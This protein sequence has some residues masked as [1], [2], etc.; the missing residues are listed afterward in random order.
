LA[1]FF[2]FAE[3]SGLNVSSEFNVDNLTAFKGIDENSL[4]VPS[5][6]ENQEKMEV[7]DRYVLQKIV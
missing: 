7:D 6:D 5:G 1:K 3:R 2:P 4:D